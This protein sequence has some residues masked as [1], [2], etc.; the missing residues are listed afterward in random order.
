MRGDAH[1]DGFTLALPFLPPTG[2]RSVRL[3]GSRPYTSPET[4]RFRRHVALQVATALEGWRI[5]GPGQPYT[6]TIRMALS[7][8]RDLDNAAK[9]LVDALHKA[10]AIPDD[11]WCDRMDLIRDCTIEG[12]LIEARAA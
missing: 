2:N 3:R 7:R 6:L 9:T 10:R 1:A 8:R 4:I 11:N 5:V 12:C